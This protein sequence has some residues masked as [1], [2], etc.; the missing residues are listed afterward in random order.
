MKIAFV[1]DDFPAISQ[2]FIL[3]QINGV[4]EKGHA[5]DIYA[6]RKN[7]IEIIQPE[8]VQNNLPDRVVYLTQPKAGRINRLIHSSIESPRNLIWLKPL[9]LFRVLNI[10]K[11]KPFLKL[12]IYALPFFKLGC[13]KYDVIHCQ[14]GHIA[15]IILDLIEVGALEGKLITSFRGHDITQKKFSDKSKYSKL[16]DQGD[17]FLPVSIS[18]KKL[19]IAAGCDEKKIKVLY[20]GINCEKFNYKERCQSTNSSL[21]LLSTARLVEKKGLTYAIKAISLL[22]EKGINIEY[23]I[24]GDGPL[25]KNLERQVIDSGLQNQIKFLG[26]IDHNEVQEKLN[27]AHVFIAPSV[28]SSS[29]DKEGIPNSIKEAMAQGLPIV[30]TSH[31]GIPEL[32]ENNISG[33]L[34]P[35]RN[36]NELAD[37]IHTLYNNPK[38]CLDMG[39]QGRQYIVENFDIN[40]LNNSLISLYESV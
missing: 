21:R 34:V 23:E 38:L 12:F 27:V 30:A 2:T 13:K 31:S 36:V 25:R 6:L 33:F 8:M 32:I 5:V 26:W 1:L 37:K 40:N 10:F 28:T 3:N 11:Y 18:L 22:I 39:K 20:S 14:F 9:L 35:E 24:I 4:I 29:G 7:K 19:L 15:P 16:F 17:L